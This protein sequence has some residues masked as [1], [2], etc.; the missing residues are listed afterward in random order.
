MKY[1]TT[2]ILNGVFNLF[3][4]LF[5]NEAGTGHKEGIECITTL[6]Y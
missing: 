5:F 6:I 1:E 4:V 2:V 3:T